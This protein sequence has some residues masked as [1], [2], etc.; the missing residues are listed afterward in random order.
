M[1]HLNRM[2]NVS[3]LG[4]MIAVMMLFGM[5]SKTEATTELRKSMAKLAVKLQKVLK[6][7]NQDTVA[8]GQFNGPANF[9]NSSS[10][11][12]A[13]L[14]SEELKKL[15]INVKTSARFGVNG[16]FRL[17][18]VP[19]TDS[20]DARLGRK[21]LA[22]KIKIRVVVE[23]AFGN[24][25]GA[26]NFEDTIKGEATVV[27]AL[28]LVTKLAPDETE[29]ERDK[30]LRDS[31]LKPKTNIQGAVIRSDP[32]SDYGMEILVANTPRKPTSKDGF[33]FVHIKRGE[34]YKVR[35][36]NNSPYEAAAQLRIDGLS[37]FAFSELK[38]T[39]GAKK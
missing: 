21:V 10:P 32:K 14:L 33:A 17:A 36:I 30:K 27:N 24:P 6:D 12:F 35:L 1:S 13:Q 28:G 34:S 19:A 15:Q 26:F 37:M 18:E 22:V 31:L 4:C 3:I 16:E 2:S 25:L 11:G 5:H 8:I 38:H 7:E 39:S 9:P 29:S 20:F 23:D